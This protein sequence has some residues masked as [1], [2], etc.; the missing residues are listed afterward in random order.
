MKKNKD[1]LGKIYS[2]SLTI[3]KDPKILAIFL[4]SIFVFTLL[5]LP[6]E[7]TAT[8]LAYVHN[9]FNISSIVKTILLPSISINNTKNISV[10]KA[11]V[12]A[13][14]TIYHSFL[15]LSSAFK[16]FKAFAIYA[17]SSFAS[18]F[19]ILI[20]ILILE[21]V[22][23]LMVY[24]QNVSGGVKG[25]INLLLTII[26]MCIVFMLPIGIVY[27]YGLALIPISPGFAALGV[28]IVILD[29]LLMAY[30]SVRLVFSQIF[31]IIGKDPISAIEGS[32][33]L[34]NK[35]WWYVFVTLIIPIFLISA[36][37]NLIFGA[38]ASLYLPTSALMISIG[39]SYTII[40]VSAILV[41]YYKY[42][43]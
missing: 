26:V 29:I 1:S 35:K 9:H 19:L 23:V 10:V 38:L 6:Y 43:S 41:K 36:V 34:T 30:L 12:S 24:K 13:N 28:I 3:I 5:Y 42:I 11:N 37:V 17:V 18:S 31:A 25:Y 16:Y 33:E 21:T 22:I 40:V 2:D 4:I 7:K 14:A 15:Q 32:F 8:N 20:A 27:G 39:L